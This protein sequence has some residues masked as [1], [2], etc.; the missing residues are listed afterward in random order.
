MSKL[1]SVYF[2][3]C[4]GLKKFEG[5]VDEDF[6]SVHFDNDAVE[7]RGN[8]EQPNFADGLEVGST[9]MYEEDAWFGFGRRYVFHEN[10]SKL[11]DFVGYHWQMVGADDPGPFRELF[12]WGGNGTIGPVVSAKLVTDFN[13]WDERAQAL[14]DSE[15]YE[16]YG[17]FRSMFEFAMKNGCVFFRCS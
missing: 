17:H 2:V 7:V 5:V 12:R 14:E 4:K 8:S 9:Y 3:A 13:E 1:M 11:A 6:R 16:F 10:L 15:F